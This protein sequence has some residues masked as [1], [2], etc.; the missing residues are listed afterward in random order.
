MFEQPVD[1]FYVR[2]SR[3]RSLLARK[4]VEHRE[5]GAGLIHALVWLPNDALENCFSELSE[6]EV[7]AVDRYMGERIR[8]ENYMPFPSSYITPTVNVEEKK[9]ELRPRYV[10]IDKLIQRAKKQSDN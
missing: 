1:A 4:L 3:Y 7:E 6:D 8:P 2:V 5:L 9:K 10:Q